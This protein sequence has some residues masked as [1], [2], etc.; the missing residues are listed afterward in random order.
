M[1]RNA[2]NDTFAPGVYIRVFDKPIDSGGPRTVEIHRG[3]TGGVVVYY[4]NSVVVMNV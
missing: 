1:V 2:N 4:V 3:W